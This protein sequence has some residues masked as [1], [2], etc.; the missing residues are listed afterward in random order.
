[1]TPD[2]LKLPTHDTV[3][4]WI[5]STEEDKAAV[6]EQVD[7]LVSDPSF[8]K[9][10]RYPSLLRFV[11]A[12][13]LDGESESLKERVL[14]IEVFDRP[15]DYDSTR[16]SIVRV[17]AAELRKRILHYYD[18]PVHQN[19]L[20]VSLPAGSYVPQFTAPTNWAE[21][22][23]AG[24]ETHAPNLSYAEEASEPVQEHVL[25][26]EARR[27]ASRPRFKRWAFAAAAVVIVLAVAVLVRRSE[28]ESAF[29]VFWGP[30]FQSPVPILI[31]IND[32]PLNSTQMID[33]TNP[34]LMARAANQTQV[35]NASNVSLVV[36]LTRMF[37]EHG[38]TSKVQ[39]QSRTTFGDLRG[40]P[41]VLLGAYN[42]YWT[43]KMT[44]PLRYHFTNNADMTTFWIED[45]QAPQ[46]K[47]WSSDV[48]PGVRIVKDY[49]LIARFVPSSTGQTIYVIAGLRHP[50]MEEGVK[51]LLSPQLLDQMMSLDAAGKRNKNV[52]MVIQTEVV[53]GVAGKP[54][55]LAVHTW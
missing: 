53:D 11:V 15:P 39:A 26:D 54:S 47:D 42:N 46:M 27:S 13:S 38:R 10:K 31:C 19:E 7:R 18:D 22:R 20:R 21:S 32:Q 37:A 43:L 16:D 3:P 14:G 41:L 12:K 36:D 30:A 6:W 8:N 17:T 40:G 45:R 29:D 28:K 33:A 9:S 1:L 49:A 25:P 4:D 51:L 35:M 44:A 55:V 48:T 52:E 50:S 2:T 5:P 24:R 23:D 34:V